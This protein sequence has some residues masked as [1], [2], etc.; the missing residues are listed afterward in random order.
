MVYW[1]YADEVGR[2]YVRVEG[3]ITNKVQINTRVT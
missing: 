3:F 1:I 2:V